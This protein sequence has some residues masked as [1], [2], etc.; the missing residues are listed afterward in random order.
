[1]TNPYDHRWT[2]ANVIAAAVPDAPCMYTIETPK[3]IPYFFDTTPHEDQYHNPAEVKKVIVFYTQ[4]RTGKRGYRRL[5]VSRVS[6]DTMRLIRDRA[7]ARIV[8]WAMLADVEEQRE[9]QRRQIL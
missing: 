4:L 3:E 6:P 8:R 7:R 2:R 9:K 1:M 5:Y